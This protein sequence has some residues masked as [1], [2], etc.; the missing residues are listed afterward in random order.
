MYRHAFMCSGLV[1]LLGILGIIGAVTDSPRLTSILPDLSSMTFATALNL[2]MAGAALALSLPGLPD[3]TSRK[4]HI[5]ACLWM[6]RILA[7]SILLISFLHLMAAFS[8]AH[9]AP[10]DASSG[11]MPTT[12][13]GN[14]MVPA[15]TLNFLLMGSALLLLTN[16]TSIALF[17]GLA[18]ATGISVW[19][20]SSCYL[21]KGE[22]L[23][24]FGKMAPTTSLAF[25]AL[26]IG[27]LIARPDV[28]L[29]RLYRSE[30]A[31]GA[32]LRRM[33]PYAIL[34]PM[35]L[36]WLRLQGQRM[37]WY[38]TEAGLALFTAANITVF[39]AIIWINA[40]FLDRS[41]AERKRMEKNQLQL[42][43]IVESSEDAIIAKTLNG[44]IT[45]WNPGAERL[46]G[47]SA[48]EAIGQPM[49]ICIPQERAN[50]EVEILKKI[51]LGERV[52]HFDT[53]RKR[54]DGSPIEVSVTVS[55]I[56]DAS[57]TII[58]ASK[59]A[60]D[61]S[62][63]KRSELKLR[64]QLARL[65]LLRLIASATAERQDIKSIFQVVLHN[66][67]EHLE[68]DFCCACLYETAGNAL[69]VINVGTRSE[70]L[71][72]ELD[73]LE[74]A[75]IPIDQNGLSRCISGHLVY[76]P[77][78]GQVA[79][80][81]PM[82]LS[83]GG[84]RA[85]VAVPLMVD[86]SV[87]GVLIAARRQAESFSSGECEFL[88]QLGEQVALASHQAQLHHSLQ[89]AYDDLR[90]SQQAAVQQER[91]RALGQ[92]AAGVAH[93]I[94]NALSP[95]ALYSEWLLDS[96]PSLSDRTRKYLGI[97]SRAIEDVATTIGRLGEF[98]RQREQQP[99]LEAVDVNETV[100]E[101]L[102]LTRARWSDMPQQRGL[103][104][105]AATDLAPGL[106]AILGVASEI[107]EAL[108]NLVFNAVDAMPKGGTIAVKTALGHA[109]AASAEHGA[110]QTV[111]LS[112]SDT[113]TGMDEETRRRCLEPFFTTKGERGTGLGLAMVYGMVRRHHAD[114]DIDSA[115]GSGTT[116]RITFP[117]PQA[118][119]QRD[120]PAAI[121]HM[122]P[123]LRLLVIDDDPILLKSL[124]DILEADGH[125]VTGE[126]ISKNAID[127]FSAALAK[128]ERYDAVITD[129]GMPYVDGRQ[130]ASAVKAVSRSTPVILLT[131][132]GKRMVADGDMPEHVDCVLSK[133]PKLTELRNALVRLCT[134]AGNGEQ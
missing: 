43:A 5:N 111:H 68:I 3:Q 106:P 117:V 125:A 128:G 120:L 6:A 45:S 37:G 59:I 38:G 13:I 115:M 123:R 132:W 69:S 25:L 66:L 102:E 18:L 84:L 17:Q 62:E 73:L 88:R 67:E 27:L 85:L 91:L 121:L 46:F 96:E 29:V 133:P 116:M 63:R 124:R 95:V 34:I 23:S 36:G 48:L 41:D 28:G 47:F 7:L 104:I 109:T 26:S 42:A 15:T 110:G 65:D 134:S 93:D 2:L 87:F 9:S 52:E 50:E 94:N 107:R 51:V 113:G 75:A 30:S 33:V 16:M 1:V 92:M 86:S 60:R 77:D 58:G 83:R 20:S 78:V 61:N 82:R 40:R 131:G 108:I 126:N 4:R 97:M 31:G 57:G 71:A 90:Q 21:F 22:S 11:T 129:L 64:Q 105:N 130:V 119:P 19:L 81:F 53:V 127:R 70:A 122:P 118:N 80:P 54:K 56:K 79:F 32:L 39:G 89:Q 100:R 10:G 112:V 35:I 76:E 49:L 98:Y 44:I 12:S 55:P 74:K 101:V 103:M 8:P 14:V 24:F 99:V 114:I 72:R